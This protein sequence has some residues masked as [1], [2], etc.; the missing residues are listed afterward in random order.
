MSKGHSEGQKF[1]SEF[2]S[3]DN[4]QYNAIKHITRDHRG[5]NNK[6]ALFKER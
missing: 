5:W 6:N 4:K 3:L 2:K 1:V